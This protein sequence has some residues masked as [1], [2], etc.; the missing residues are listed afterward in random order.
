MVWAVTHRPLSFSMFC[1]TVCWG[2]GCEPWYSPIM[3]HKRRS[4]DDHWKCGFQ[5]LLQF[6]MQAFQVL[7]LCDPRAIV[8][9]IKLQLGTHDALNCSCEPL[10]KVYEQLFC[11]EC[12]ACL[13]TE[14]SLWK[15][16]S[17]C[18]DHSSGAACKLQVENSG[19]SLNLLFKWRHSLINS[20]MRSVVKY[21]S[22]CVYHIN[23][24]RPFW[25]FH[26]RVSWTLCP[27]VPY[28]PSD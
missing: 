19:L 6:F 28:P 25:Y 27:Q 3:F 22:Y 9:G 26:K 11:S 15:Q 5:N 23:C 10:W 2:E 20:L 17:W 16:Q 21:S 12:D 7:D 24:V 18:V 14:W 4:C 8:I 1:S 13:V